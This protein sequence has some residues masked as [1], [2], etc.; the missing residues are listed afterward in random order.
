MRLQKIYEFRLLVL[1]ILL[2]LVVA[3]L[4]VLEP[5]KKP[6]LSV[7]P[8]FLVTV[9][10]G[11]STYAVLEIENSGTADDKLIGASVDSKD[12][13]RA[14]LH[15]KSMSRLDSVALPAGEQVL[16]TGDPHIMLIDAQRG[17]MVGE[18]VDIT[19]DFE[20][21]SDKVVTFTV[22]QADGHNHTH[23]SGK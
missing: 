11:D 3:L 21:T 13:S 20:K 4:W 12:A 16:M 22:T 2:F 1:L 17:I 6:D 5:A 18:K 10:E 19:L 9:H 8:G 14:E 15:D 23:R 7:K